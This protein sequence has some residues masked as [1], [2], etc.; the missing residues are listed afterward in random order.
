M[1]CATKLIKV[2]VLM[3]VGHHKVIQTV[4]ALNKAGYTDITKSRVKNRLKTLKDRWREVH[5]LFNGLTGFAW[6]PVTNK[7]EAEEEVWAELIKIEH[8]F[9]MH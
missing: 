7:F 3:V 6:N 9:R 2:S 5:D 1:Q 8:L 4:H